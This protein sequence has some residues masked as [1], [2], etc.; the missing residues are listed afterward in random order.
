[1]TSYAS[2]I[3]CDPHGRP[4]STRVTRLK[5]KK[6]ES[7]ASLV[8]RVV[9]DMKKKNNR[10]FVLN[11]SIQAAAE[12]VTYMVGVRDELKKQLKLHAVTGNLNTGVVS[13][14]RL[15]EDLLSS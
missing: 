3:I 13:G 2:G 10:L 5:R 14:L 11:V 9:N 12:R 1:M 4:E 6:T 8:K 7:P 15:C